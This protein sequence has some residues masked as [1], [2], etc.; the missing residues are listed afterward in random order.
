MKPTSSRKPEQDQTAWPRAVQPGREVVTVYRRKTPSGNWAFMVANYADGKRRFDAY[1]AEADALEAADKLA[2]LIDKRKYKAAA[3]TEEQAVEYA[4]AALALVPFNV[5]VGAGVGA[6]V[7]CLKIVAD[8][9]NLHAAVKFYRER[10][11]TIVAKP[12]ADVVADMLKVKAADGISVR[13]AK[14]LRLRLERFAKD[15]NKLCCNV[16]TAD[17]QAWFD[18]LDLSP[19]SRR[20]YRTVLHALFS[21]AVARGYAADNPVVGV[22]KAKVHNADV[23]IFKPAEI[24]RLLE[25]CR[26]HYPDYLPSLA[27]G[28]F[29]GLRSSE[30][31]RLEFGAHVDFAGRQIVLN[32]GITKTASRRV[33]PMTE[34]LLAWLAPYAGR[35]QGKVWPGGTVLFYRRQ[36]QIALATAV[37]ADEANGIKAQKAVAWKGNAL[38]HSY[39]SYRFAQSNDAGRVAGELGN[40]AAVV[41]RHYKE[42]VKPADAERWFN[43]KPEG[44]ASN[45][46]PLAAVAGA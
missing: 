43:V 11:K 28:A 1:S 18:G 8:L 39:A 25:A 40:S 24:A 2:R 17:L 36:Q 32:M 41:H 23:E 6:L 3:I 10:H 44:E 9:S 20:N 45:V 13:Y 5:T 35:Q 42:V 26:T 46:L 38:R 21:H 34:N 12:V 14:D 7:E 16:T 4:T 22:Q 33:V 30:I 27:I 15:C 19:Q 37:E 29:T 31:E